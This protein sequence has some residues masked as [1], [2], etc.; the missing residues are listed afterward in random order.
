MGVQYNLGSD[1]VAM[2]MI[3]WRLRQ[4]MDDEGI[5]GKELAQELAVSANA[6]SN[7]RKPEMPRLNGDGLNGL[8]VAL[9]KLR[10]PD[11]GL[12]DVGDLIRFSL[13]PSELS[14]LGVDA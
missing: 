8:L 10:A 1:F 9:N 11:R 2:T 13:S 5:Q 7:L 3:Q 12:I 14:E 6:V 4:V